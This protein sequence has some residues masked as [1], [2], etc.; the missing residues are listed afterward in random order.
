MRTNAKVLAE[1]L[2]EISNDL[3]LRFDSARRGDKLSL[4]SIL[5]RVPEEIF[6][7]MY[8]PARER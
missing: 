7:P 6:D 3:E 2:E 5:G 1:R 8:R 4:E